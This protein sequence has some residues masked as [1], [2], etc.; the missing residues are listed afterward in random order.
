ME[1]WYIKDTRSLKTIVGHD[2]QNMKI[3]FLNNNLFYTRV[4]IYVG[5]LFVSFNS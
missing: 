1:N 5:T 2:H 3:K 4:N